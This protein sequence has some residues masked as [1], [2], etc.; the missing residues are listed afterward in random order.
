LRARLDSVLARIAG[1]AEK[2]GRDPGTIRLVCIAK[3]HGAEAVA[4][5]AR[6]WQG[7]HPLLVGENYMQE[8]LEKQTRVQSL[9]P[10][11]RVEWHF[12]GHVQSRKA[13][14]IPGRFAL[15][16]TVDSEKLALTLQRH[17]R[18]LP[19]S[20]AGRPRRAQAVLLQVNVGREP[21]KSGVL[22][23]GAE[24]LAAFVAG[25]P[26]LSLQGLMCIPPLD[27][28][29]EDSR[30]FF[31]ALREARDSIAARLGVAL[32]ELS[33]GMSRDLEAAVEEGATLVRVGTD[34]FGA[35]ALA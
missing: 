24:K 6:V 27:G 10:G 11:C 26:E 3:M 7:P 22:P 25:L 28:K 5:L 18:A 34:I 2:A 4:A 31:A 12:A 9:V 13:G 17:I 1:A 15:L 29:P 16:H 19:V 8:A 21:Q 35:R 23:E 30:P 20:D 33:M 32:P 14:D